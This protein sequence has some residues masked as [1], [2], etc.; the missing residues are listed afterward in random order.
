[1]RGR[2]RWRRCGAMHGRFQSTPPCGGDCCRGYIFVRVGIS[3]HAPMR[4]RPG[5]KWVTSLDYDFNPRPHAGATSSSRVANVCRKISI[6]APMRG[7]HFLIISDS[8]TIE[9][10]STPP[11][12]GDGRSL[13]SRQRHPHFNPRPHAGATG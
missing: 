8:H 5:S 12:G 11:C 13:R 4:G 1:M 6:H 7:R 10:Q 9:F 2:P 3:I